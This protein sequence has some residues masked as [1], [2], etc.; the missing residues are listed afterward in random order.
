MH[1][2]YHIL[3]NHYLH[4]LKIDMRD[5][6]LKIFKALC[7]E[8]KDRGYFPLTV[9]EYCSGKM[10][11][12]DKNIILRH[13]VDRKIDTVLR[14]ANC[15]Y[16]M[17]IRATYYFRY[18]PEVFKPAIIRKIE[19]L[20]HEIGYHY[21]VLDKTNGNNEQ[22]IVLF[23]KELERMREI[24]DIQTICMHGNPLK[25]WSNRDLWKS[26]DY[27]K[28]GIVGEPYLSIDYNKFLYL[29]DTGRSWSGKYSV[30]D[31]VDKPFI[32]KI[33]HTEDIINL[34]QKGK[35]PNIC[36]LVHPNRWSDNTVEWCGELIWQNFK[37]LGKQFLKKAL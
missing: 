37:N 3:N 30:K 26:Y 4:I 6:T 10:D 21:E 22:A 16:E 20:N 24:A 14:M 9:S 15:E 2:K 13:D 29:S 18:T 32:E 19:D 1:Y 11:S 28:F 36:L 17:N 12:N 5:F 31:I 7:T 23:E 25:P 35:Y 34:I 33:R 8:V 27:R